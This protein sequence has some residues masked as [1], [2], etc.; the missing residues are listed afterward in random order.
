MLAAGS[1]ALLAQTLWAPKGAPAVYRAP[2]KPHTKLSD[3]QV[4]HQGKADWRQV[5]VDDEHLRSEYIQAKPGTAVKRALHPDT[6]AWWVVMDGEVRFDIETV[7]PFTARKGSIVQAPMQT[8][9]SWEVVGDKPALIF[10]TNIAGAR[11]LYGSEGMPPKL[12]DGLAWTPVLFNNRK[13]AAWEKNNKP[14]TTF[15]EV[16]AALEAGKLKGTI[17]IVEDARG[18]ANFIYGYNSKLPPLDE[19]NKGHYHPECAEYWLIMK[20]QI[21]YPI[22]KAGVFIAGE[23][24]VVYVPRY[25]F[26]AP[27]WWGEGASCRLA[28][29]G[30]PDIAHLFEGAPGTH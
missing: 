2:H 26:H 24:D 10:E 11:T 20:G 3:L 21:R 6:R 22:E 25:T 15:D 8:F 5:I 1:A 17:R 23:G 9:F 13:I 18:T 27:R 28:L 12:A 14:H 7:E 16:A 19:K 29:N 4:K 30:Y